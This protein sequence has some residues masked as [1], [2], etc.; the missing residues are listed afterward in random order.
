MEDF[1]S[2]VYR[3]INTD[4]KFQL[5]KESSMTLDL[6]EGKIVGITIDLTVSQVENRKFMYIFY[7]HYVYISMGKTR[8]H[9]HCQL[10]FKRYVTL[11][12]IKDLFNNF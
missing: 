9:A 8:P 1:I 7:R 4:C 3:Q 11:I 6:A 12:V 10:L 5:Q 2:F